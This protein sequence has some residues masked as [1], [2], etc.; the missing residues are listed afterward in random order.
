MAFREGSWLP[1]HKGLSDRAVHLRAL[2]T[3][4][5]YEISG[6]ELYINWQNFAEHGGLARLAADAAALPAGVAVTVEEYYW[7]DSRPTPRPSTRTLALGVDGARLGICETIAA[8]EYDG[9]AA[10]A[11]TCFVSWLGVPA[12]RRNLNAEGCAAPRVV[13]AVSRRSVY[14]IGGSLHKTKSA[15]PAEWLHGP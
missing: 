4:R 10:L 11:E 6:G 1:F 12:E 5:G 8:A 13:E 9:H 7:D 2:L 15:A 14:P 3:M